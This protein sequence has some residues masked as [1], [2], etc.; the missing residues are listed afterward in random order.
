MRSAV[1]P[2]VASVV[3]WAQFTG[4]A[5][6]APSIVL[7]AGIANQGLRLRMNG[8]PAA[9][10]LFVYGSS[11]LA[12]VSAFTSVILQTNVITA[13][14]VEFILPYPAAVVTNRFFRAGFWPG[15]NPGSNMV[16]IPAG[17]FTMGSPDTEPARYPV[18]GPLTLVT[19]SRGFWMGRFEV[20]QGEFEEI[21]GR[22]P[23][24]FLGDPRLPVEQVEWSVAVAYCEELT[25][26]E[27]SAGR[28]PSGYVYRLPTEAE[29]EYACRAGS[30][31]P[32]HFGGGLHSGQ[33][34]FQGAY[35]YPPCDDLPDYCPNPAGVMLDRTSPVGSYAANAWGLHDMHGNVWEWCADWWA[36]SHPGGSVTDPAGPPETAPK[37]IRGGGWQSYAVHCR[38]ASRLDSNPIHAN[39]DVGFRV[40][41][42][43]GP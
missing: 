36:E 2:L 5:V 1:C 11:N 29:W 39:Y 21:M 28:L 37:V 40:V 3:L 8:L 20:T 32:F 7:E 42:A 35:E 23:S 26:R 10:A 16:Y 14:M 41:L 15:F 30:S 22:N 25:A 4:I 38:S 24:N 31:A 33:A 18:E 19:I 17:S 34:N 12:G 9:G 27:R 13:G 43:P 6:A